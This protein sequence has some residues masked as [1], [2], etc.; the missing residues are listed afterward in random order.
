MTQ[1]L[2]IPQG[3]QRFC[4]QKPRR[5]LSRRKTGVRVPNTTLLDVRFVFARKG[6]SATFSVFALRT[7]GCSDRRGKLDLLRRRRSRPFAPTGV[8]ACLPYIIFGKQEVTFYE[9]NSYARLQKRSHNTHFLIEMMLYDVIRKSLKKTIDQALD[10]I[11]KDGRPKKFTPEQIELA[12]SLLEQGK[13]YRQIT[14]M[15]GI[16][17]STLIR[18][19]REA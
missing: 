18:A 19:K 2:A 4:E 6:R 14:T 15:T 3:L 5:A 17:K 11:F 9:Q 8:N 16:S 13:T 10:D 12:L 7:G 1:P